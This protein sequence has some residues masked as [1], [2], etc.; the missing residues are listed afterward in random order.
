MIS[1]FSE[2]QYER[3]TMNEEHSDSIVRLSAQEF[4]R[5]LISGVCRLTIAHRWPNEESTVQTNPDDCNGWVFVAL[6]S[7]Y[8]IPLNTMHGISALIDD[9]LHISCTNNEQTD[10]LRVRLHT[11]GETWLPIVFSPH[12][13]M[14]QP[15]RPTSMQLA[16]VASVP[17]LEPHLPIKQPTGRIVQS[18]LE[19]QAEE[20]LVKPVTK[21]GS[22]AKVVSTETQTDGAKVPQPLTSS[23]KKRKTKPTATTF[24]D[25]HTPSKK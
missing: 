9:A 8:S 15:Q 3:T 20:A 13:V 10:E 23:R 16:E 14:L 1:H 12:I 7:K 22:R 2:P 24:E 17:L 11:L 21:R 25:I 19:L 5:W 18:E 6:P 4:D